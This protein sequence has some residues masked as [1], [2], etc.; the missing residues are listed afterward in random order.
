VTFI[1]AANVNRLDNL[2]KARE[3]AKT[4]GDNMLNDVDPTGPPVR[5]FGN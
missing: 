4:S 3:W 2:A 5:A 1:L